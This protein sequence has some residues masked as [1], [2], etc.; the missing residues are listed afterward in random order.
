[1]A[2]ILIGWESGGGFG[3]VTRIRL[4]ARELKA[5]GHEPVLALRDVVEPAPLLDRES[6]P[7]LQGPCWSR[8]TPARFAAA[9]FADIL[10]VTG[11]ADAGDLSALLRAWDGLFSVVR[12]DLV[13]AEYAPM[14]V[15][16]ARGKFPTV[17]FGSGFTV[18]P[19]DLALYPRLQPRVKVSMPE[20]EVLAVVQ[21]AQKRRG[22]P[23]PQKLSEIFA[24]E[25]RFPCTFPELDPYRAVRREPLIPPLSD[26]PPP[27]K[28]PAKPR[29]FAY[30]AADAHG[31]PRFIS[32][33]V[34][35]G[36]PGGMFLR[37]PAKAFKDAMKKTNVTLYEDPQPMAEVLAGSS[38]VVH[39]G[40]AGTSEACLTSGRP[41]VLFPRHLEQSLT[42]RSLRT[43]GVA[44]TIG[45][46]T[47]VETMAKEIR[48]FAENKAALG[49]AAALSHEIAARGPR[50]GV[51]PI[52]DA[53]EELLAQPREAAVL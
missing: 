24:C 48:E 38:F 17:M 43:A 37:R 50:P 14:M 31:L 10:S 32:G 21:E 15:L 41:Q 47:A 7:V 18:P 44:I 36:V 20:A 9:T 51:A 26:L 11:F 22:G 40:G 34:K 53:C 23:V 16:A 42:A 8:P 39:H 45:R 30:L 35:S 29:F 49:R 13:L 1:M 12:P 6:Y 19:A 3:H 28:P 25:R 33:L 52:V 2:K 4:A 46:D 5:R 27:M